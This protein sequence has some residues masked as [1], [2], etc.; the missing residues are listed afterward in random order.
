M[1]AKATLILTV[2]LFGVLGAWYTPRLRAADREKGLRT[3]PSKVL[4]LAQANPAPNR[5]LPAGPNPFLPPQGNNPFLPPEPSPEPQEAVPGLLEELSALEAF[6]T[7]SPQA[8]ETPRIR[9]DLAD[10]YRVEGRF[11]RSLEHWLEAWAATARSQDPAQKS[12]ADRS[13]VQMAQLLASLGRAEDLELLMAQNS[14][15]TF[16][17]GRLSASWAR[18]REALA[19]MR[20]KPWIAYKCGVYALNNVAA[21]LYGQKLLSIATKP[22]SVRGFSMAELQQ[23]AD[24]HRLGLVAAFREPGAPLIYPSVV[25]W[26]QNHYAAIASDTPLGLRVEDPTFGHPMT[27]SPEAI[28]EEA[29]GYFLVPKGALPEGWRLAEST[30]ISQVFGK[31]YPWS[32]DDDEGNPCEAGDCCD[33][34]GGGG[35]SGPAGTGDGTNEC[36]MARWRVQEPNINLVVED[37]PMK[38]DAAFGPDFVLSV[39]WRQ[40]EQLPGGGPYSSLSDGWYCDL[41]SQIEAYPIAKGGTG[42]ATFR[43]LSGDGY[44]YLIHFANGATTSDRSYSKDLVAK[45]TVVGV[46]NTVIEVYYSNGAYEKFTFID[47]AWN[48]RLVERRDA[49]T[50]GLNFYYDD[51]GG[52]NRSNRLLRIDTADGAQFYFN[53][54]H[55]SNNLLV[56]SVTGPN[57]RSVTFGYSNFGENVKLTSI[58]DVV[59]LTSSFGYD[60]NGNVNLLVTPYGT[61]TFTHYDV[62]NC[63]NP[64]NCEGIDRYLI[65]SEPLG[66]KQVY[67]FYDNAMHGGVNELP[68]KI[69]ETFAA[70]QIPLYDANTNDPPIRTIDT[71]RNQRNSHYWN[72]Q[73]AAQLSTSNPLFFTAADFSLSRTK[74]WL[75]GY[76][77]VLTLGTLSWVLPPSPTGSTN[78]EAQP[79]FYDYG[80]KPDPGFGQPAEPGSAFRGTNSTP[81]VVI[82]RRKDGATWTTWY[83]H[84]RRNHRGMRTQVEERWVSGGSILFRTNT[85]K[86]A[87]APSDISRDGLQLIEHRGPYGELIRGY[88]LHG[89][90]PDQYGRATNAVGDVTIYNYDANRRLTSIQT[91]AGLI[92]TYGYGGDGRL[93]SVVDTITGATPRTNLYTWLSGFLRTHTDPRNLTRTFS[94]DLLGR[95]TQIDHPDS[96]TEQFFY[97]LPAGVGFNLGGSATNILDLVYRKDRLNYYWTNVPNRL[98]QVE[99]IVEPPR[100]TGGAGVKTFLQYCGCGSPTQITR[101][102]GIPGIEQ[103]T[104]IEYDFQ[105][106]PIRVLYPEQTGITNTYDVLGR[107]LTRTDAFIQET[108]TYD[109]LHRLVALTNAAGHVLSQAYDL[110]DR[111]LQLRDAN[112][113]L[114]TNAYDSLGR[115]LVRGYPDGGVERWAYSTGLD[116]PTQYI[117]QV[118]NTNLWTYDAAQRLKTEA[119]HGVY[120]NS[121]TYSAGDDL[122]QLV[123]GKGQTTTWQYDAYG[124]LTN[125][126]N[127]NGTILITNLFDANRRLTKRWTPSKGVT[128]YSYDSVANLTNVSY[129]SLTNRYAFDAVNRLT[130]MVDAVGTTKYTYT[131][132]GG[133]E[134]TAEDGPWASDT[135]TTTNRLGRRMG[136]GLQQPSG[137]WAVAHSY[138]AGRIASVTSPAGTFSYLYTNTTPGTAS[139]GRLVGR[140]LLPTTPASAL[141]TNAFDSVGRLLSTRL[142]TSTNVTLN[143]HEYLNNA[144][145]QRTVATRTNSSQTAWNGRIGFAYDKAQQLVTAWSTNSAGA[146]VTNECWGYLYDRA[147]NLN[148][149]TNNAGGSSISTYTVNNLNQVTSGA[150]QSCSY[151]TNGN[152]IARGGPALEYDAENQL[153]LYTVVSG[154]RTEFVYDGL[155]RMRIR[156]EY[157]WVSGTNYSL[158]SQTGYLYDGMRAIQERTSLTTP[159]VAYTRGADLS[160]T[161]EGAGGIGGM[162]GRSHGYSAGTW[163]THHFYHA[164]GN[165]NIT[166]LVNT[167]QGHGCSYQYSPYG[168]LLNSA[169]GT[170]TATANAYRFSSKEF[171]GNPGLYYYGFRFYDPN[172]QRWINRDPLEEDGGVNLYRFSENSPTRSV[173]PYGL[174]PSLNPQNQLWACEA[175]ETVA[176]STG[177]RAAVDAAVKAF[178]ATKDAARQALSKALS[179]GNGPAHHIATLEARQAPIAQRAAQGGF[180][181]NGANNGIRLPEWM[182]KGFPKWHREW[183]DLLKRTLNDL[184]AKHP[185]ISP[186]DAARFLQDLVNLEKARLQQCVARGVL[187]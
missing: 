74:H 142:N 173:D 81:S 1:K 111:I 117:D 21:R 114:T 6:V 133:Y 97:S 144:A 23:I 22:S 38:Y 31:G 34:E 162:L 147:L 32:M 185:D 73:Q 178:N 132:T 134:I 83:Q 18:T 183:N 24:E 42:E 63:G 160:S 170:L 10:H 96:T 98:R 179:G 51:P 174:S 181:W 29:S 61:N 119:V 110:Q 9:T 113:V 8:P 124:G 166:Y 66:A 184:Y 168:V 107:L 169:S 156:N 87:S 118:G 106:K 88:S 28:E 57:S 121:F 47:S 27:M 46:T 53:Y 92:S 127:A 78:D 93:A 89:S 19:H 45:R 186:A 140:I 148:S 112:R 26:K 48:Y 157:N 90:Y 4:R 20:R 161:L 102:Q 35:G 52:L 136:L 94:Y 67:L 2:L 115:V 164:D 152:M 82:Q 59:N 50:K 187:P 70:S 85:F 172:L 103:T 171:I 41:I 30:E 99:L 69:P 54:N 139:A 176:G 123:D 116:G 15:R 135:L 137:T 58:R 77:P 62:G 182:H 130:N 165:G 105:G 16:D 167:S 138:N 43:L 155:G 11:T 76:D 68:G 33:A 129:P 13:L 14:G 151:D 128:T 5:F 65:V 25:H 146:Q 80:G 141:I 86:Y 84:I 3:K 95:T 37:I 44:K 7:A 79:I 180:N 36:G 49:T 120:T 158:S 149:R 72:R 91:Q 109:T 143:L 125:K 122:T 64:I 39:G 150:G 56:T 17:Y 145:H 163:S 159:A 175:V 71:A 154:P 104:T 75:A 40:R 108:N 12:V 55:P 131:L 60:A 153:V 126:A 177:R 101:A 100:V